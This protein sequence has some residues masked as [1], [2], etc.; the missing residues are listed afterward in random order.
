MLSYKL[1]GRRSHAL[2][3]VAPPRFLSSIGSLGSRRAF[4]HR[5]SQTPPT[6]RGLAPSAALM[7]RTAVATLT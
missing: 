2:G 6:W 7:T 1:G 4:V 3:E 5:H